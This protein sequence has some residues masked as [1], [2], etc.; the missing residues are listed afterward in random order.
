MR[1]QIIGAAAC[2]VLFLAALWVGAWAFNRYH[3]RWAEFPAYFTTVLVCICSA[4]GFLS[5]LFA[6]K[7][8]RDKR[9]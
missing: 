8:A 3:G 4:L 9:R 2:V 1:A 7:D 6:A 5:C